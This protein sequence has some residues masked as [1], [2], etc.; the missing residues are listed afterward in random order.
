LV[1]SSIFTGFPTT[2]IFDTNVATQLAEFV[3]IE[4]ERGT[5]NAYQRVRAVECFF[6]YLSRQREANATPFSELKETGARYVL[7]HISEAIQNF[8][9]ITQGT[10][11]APDALDF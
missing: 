1:G 6:Q 9:N 5:T 2:P 7:T 4:S 10:P 8:K 3:K 11:E